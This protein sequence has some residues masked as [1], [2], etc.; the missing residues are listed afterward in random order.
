MKAICTI[1]FLVNFLVVNP[2]A[3]VA[4]FQSEEIIFKGAG[5]N[6][7]AGSLTLPSSNGPYP[8]IV[9]LGGSE[10]LSRTAIYNWANADSIVSRGIAVFSFDSPGT[11]KSEG[12]RWLRTHQERTE[13]ALAAIRAPR[14]ER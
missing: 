5:N 6:K 8:A 4:Q 12:N 14:G 9:L 13:D 10:R 3:V 7:L 11:D 2:N 1:I